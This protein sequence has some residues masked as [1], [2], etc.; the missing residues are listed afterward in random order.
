MSASISVKFTTTVP[1]P[2]S[3]IGS[4][5]L[6]AEVVEYSGIEAGIFVLQV[7]PK[8]TSGNSIAHFSHIANPS[9]MAKYPEDVPGDSPYFRVDSIQLVLASSEWCSTVR[10]TI[11]R[12]IQYL[13]ECINSESSS[14]DTVVFS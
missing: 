13:V 1:D 14:E 8:D 11:E 12:D 9:D 4:Y 6:T 10:D 5:T 3:G 2:V 7:Y